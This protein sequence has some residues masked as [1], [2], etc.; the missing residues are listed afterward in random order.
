MVASIEL[1]ND[2]I[3]EMTINDQD[4]MAIAREYFIRADQGRADLFELFHEDAEFYFPKFG[5]GF[6]RQSIFEMVK[7]FDGILE[8][9][10]HDYDDLTFIPS[11]EYLG[12][13]GTS[14]GKMSGKIWAGGKTPGGRFCNVFKFRD[15]RI[16]SLHV[17]LDPD[18]TGEDEE[19]FRW[20]KNRTW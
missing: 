11:G 5:F 15:Q 7:G 12:V 16:A 20:G 10:Q 1:A 14:H 8:N 2:R 13:E 6:G 9:I 3:N 17:Y 4:K 19:R 18:Y